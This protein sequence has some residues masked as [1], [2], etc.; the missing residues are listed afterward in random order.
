[1]DFYQRLNY[2][3]GNEDW[4]VEK[5]ALRINPGD[6]ILCVTASGDRPLHLLM[7][8]C[9]KVT[10]IDMNSS[11]NHLL[12]LKIAATS[13]LD[14]EEYLAFLGCETTNHRFSM[15]KKIKS[16]LSPEAAIYWNNNK[17]MIELG[18]IYQGMVERLTRVAAKCFKLLRQKKI[19]T[20]LSFT[21]IEAQREYLTKEW[22][23]LPWRS[24]F[25][26]FLNSHI[27]KFL[28]RDPGL[29]S[30]I[31]SSIKPGKYIYQRMLR[32]L[33]SNLARKSAL[34]QLILTG[35]ILPEAYFPY[36]TFDGYSSIRKNTHKLDLRTDNIIQFLHNHNANAIN[37][38]S[39]SDIASYMPQTVFETLLEGIKHAAAPS[40]R[41]CLR[42]F[43][44][45]RQ[46][47]AHLSHSFSRHHELEN[48]LEH[49]ESNF[50]YRFC[51]G[52]IQK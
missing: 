16:H 48:K 15:F 42:E 22:D 32:Y 2:T 13:Q 14:Y 29:N 40:A 34:I 46:I 20:L 31:D 38:F 27:S 39:M 8:D 35:H 52:E 51:V 19:D 10:S 9:A 21:D 23:T 7:T 49:E 45:K 30:Y 47:P 41:F 5:Q 44:S 50:V 4:D 11:Q 24:I 33:Q 36:L 28:L 37:G 1:M 6:H 17:K 12:E 26:I 43:M 3:L 18:V 25:E